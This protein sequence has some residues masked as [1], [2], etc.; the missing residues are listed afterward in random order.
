MLA[1]Y[2]KGNLGAEDMGKVEK[3]VD[4]GLSEAGVS[5]SRDGVMSA[6]GAS[7]KEQ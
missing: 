4:N 2:A 5:D 3:G 1:D 7:L 6:V